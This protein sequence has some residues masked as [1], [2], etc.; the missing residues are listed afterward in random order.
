MRKQREREREREIAS[1]NPRS[2]RSDR[3]PRPLHATMSDECF[4]HPTPAKE[5][6]S[7]S[8]DPFF[9][10]TDL[11]NDPPLSQSDRYEQPTPELIC[12]SCEQPIPR[13]D[14]PVSDPLRDRATTFRSTHHVHVATIKSPTNRSLSLCHLSPSLTIGLGIFDFFCF[15]FCFFD[16][17]Y[18]LILCNNICLDPK[19]M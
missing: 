4:V 13:S 16:C 10:V 8:A 5:D 7:H 14:H 6:P 9:I 2:R 18:I 19:K 3:H 15:D 12:P 11:V 17:L 1:S